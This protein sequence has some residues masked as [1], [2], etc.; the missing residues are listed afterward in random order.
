[1]CLDKG[2][3]R[4]ARVNPEPFGFSTDIFSPDV[5]EFALS[6]SQC[7]EGVRTSTP[8]PP[9]EQRIVMCTG[10]EV[11]LINAAGDRLELARGD[12]VYAGPDDGELHVVGTGEVAQAYTPTPETV[13]GE[14]V[15]I[16]APFVERELRRGRRGRGSE[17][18][19]VLP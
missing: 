11:E 16:I 9:A 15:D 7:S 14:L 8:L 12:S 2:M 6:V 17:E 3:S 19:P 10:G 18:P 1:R 5:K 13:T 4:L